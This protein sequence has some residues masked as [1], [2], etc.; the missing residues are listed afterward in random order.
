M[1]SGGQSPYPGLTSF[2]LVARKMRDAQKLGEG[3]PVAQLELPRGT[4][5]CLQAFIR[6]CCCDAEHRWAENGGCVDVGWVALRGV[7]C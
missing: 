7:R 6:R 1:C 2:Q 5:A 3:K 4:P